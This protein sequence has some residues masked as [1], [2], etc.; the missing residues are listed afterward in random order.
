MNWQNRIVGHG[1][2][3]PEDLLA[4]PRNWR[5]HPQAQQAALK[6]SINDVGYVRS[7]TVNR[8]TGH[9]VDGHLRVML[10]L[11]AGV[12]A[13]PV[14]YVDLS[15]AEEAE[16]LALL[17]PIAGMAVADSEMLAELRDSI[18]TQDAAVLALLDEMEHGPAVGAFAPN[19]QPEAG[20]K[21]VSD[22]EV[23]AVAQRLDT[24]Y[25]DL[26]QANQ[27]LMIEIACPHCCEVYWLN[28]NEVLSKGEALNAED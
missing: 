28:R 7:V 1:E 17:D 26:A 11:R 23:L 19:L 9:V 22:E 25:S 18:E 16:A 10:A 5:V 12:E 4:N 13:I 21:D 2:E 14:E 20:R 6:G 27:E 24:K 8:R 3:A 15:E